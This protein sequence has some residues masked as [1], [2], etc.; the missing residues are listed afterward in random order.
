MTVLFSPVVRRALLSLALLCSIAC[1]MPAQAEVVQRKLPSAIPAPTPT[2]V[3][4]QLP[5]ANTPAVMRPAEVVLPP[6]SPPQSRDAQ[7]DCHCPSGTT[8]VRNGN[9]LPT[10]CVAKPACAPGQSRDARGNCH[11]PPD[12]IE[13]RS[14]NELSTQCVVKPA[15]VPGQ[16]RDVQGNCHCPPGTIEVRN[17]NGLPTQCVVKP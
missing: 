12:S 1:V 13:V 8:A 16:S 4:P 11:C 3:M 14:G 5:S 7:G 17:G 10:Q 15:C 2:Q 9:G 6:C